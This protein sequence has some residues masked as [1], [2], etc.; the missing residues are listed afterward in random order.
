MAKYF[1]VFLKIL[2]QDLAPLVPSS[3]LDSEF[4]DSLEI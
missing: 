1:M 3:W 2:P 4:R